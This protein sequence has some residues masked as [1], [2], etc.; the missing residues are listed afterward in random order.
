MVKSH[1]IWLAYIPGERARRVLFVYQLFAASSPVL[2]RHR[3]EIA[4]KHGYRLVA[5][6]IENA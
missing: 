6:G 3:K 2:S 5:A 1:R 4:N